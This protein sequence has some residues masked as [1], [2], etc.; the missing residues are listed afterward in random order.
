MAIKSL[1]DGIK[2]SNFNVGDNLDG[3]PLKDPIQEIVARNII[4]ISLWSDDCWSSFTWEDYQ[5]R[6]RHRVTDLEQDILEEL[7]QKGLLKFEDGTYNIKGAFISTL[8]KF[9]R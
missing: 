9:I 5:D 8:K 3:S 4:L 2:P 1:I 7:V 6:C